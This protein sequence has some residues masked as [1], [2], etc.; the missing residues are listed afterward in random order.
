MWRKNDVPWG[1][2][3]STKN[4]VGSFLGH[5]YFL[6][7]CKIDLVVGHFWVVVKKSTK[8]A[9]CEYIFFWV[10]F[11]SV[12]FL[13][14]YYWITGGG[15]VLFLVYL[16]CNPDPRTLA[17]VASNLTGDRG[18]ETG[19]SEAF[20]FFWVNF[21]SSKLGLGHW[22]FLGRFWVWVVFGSRLFFPPKLH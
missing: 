4:V 13:G 11:G 19:D 15:G 12:S 14:L 9:F 18:R 21:G 20:L 10:V 6:G 8:N 22:P 2:D 1:S 5:N 3:I 17:I 16:F 7:H